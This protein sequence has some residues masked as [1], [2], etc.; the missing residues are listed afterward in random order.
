MAKNTMRFKLHGLKNTEIKISRWEARKTSSM[1]TLVSRTANNIRRNAKRRVPV[2][3]GR[4]K[5]SIQVKYSKDK[6]AAFVR[7]VAPYSHLVEFG[8]A[9]TGANPKPFLQPA[10]DG[11]KAK[12]EQSLRK[13]L[14]GV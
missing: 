9:K 12:Y 2:V 8:S 3:T 13:I 1:R 10:Y 5:K 11:Q 6:L 4:L 14:G 7:A